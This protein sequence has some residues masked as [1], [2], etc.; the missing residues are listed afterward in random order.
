MG[1]ETFGYDIRI[2]FDCME[3]IRQG[4]AEFAQGR[5]SVIITDTN[6]MPFY[7]EALLVPLKH[8]GLDIHVLEFPAGEESKNIGTVLSVVKELL[9]R[10]VDRKSLLIALGGGVVGD[11]VGFV[12]SLY[13]RSIPYLQLP[14]SLVAQVDSSIGGKTGID[15]EEGKN[16]LGT[17]YQ[18]QAVLIDALFLETLPPE[19]FRNGLAEVIKYG[20]IESEEF[21]RMLEDGMADI[22]KYQ[23]EILVKTIE[24][25]CGIKRR[26][27]E[28]DEKDQGPRHYLNFGH[29]VG[30]ALEAASGYELSHG[31]GVALEMMAVVRLSERLCGLPAEHRQRVDALIERAGLPTAIPKDI[32]TELIMSKLTSDKKKAG[33][34]INFVL[35]RKIGEPFVAGDVDQKMVREIIEGMKND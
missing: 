15:L 16:L 23:E 18:P 35:I 5:R 28:I 10:D 17:F 20:V 25:C 7:G 32:D 30:H 9:K 6:V 1:S 8:A 24:T 3:S 11:L 14:T 27:V 29:T 34:T 21:F 12:A 22:R 2:G 19:E 13:M 33:K 31:K 26:L 4:I